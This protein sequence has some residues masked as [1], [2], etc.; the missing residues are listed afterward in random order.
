MFK[1]MDKK[2]ILGICLLCYLLIPATQNGNNMYRNNAPQVFRPDFLLV[3]L[4]GFFFRS[5]VGVIK[6]INKKALKMTS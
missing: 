4:G 6:K 3:D 1:L 2:R 5:R